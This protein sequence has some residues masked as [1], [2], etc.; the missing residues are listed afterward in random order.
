M[1]FWEFCDK[2]WFVDCLAIAGITWIAYA[3]VLN[4]GAYMRK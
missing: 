3:I 2:H 1:T 4:V